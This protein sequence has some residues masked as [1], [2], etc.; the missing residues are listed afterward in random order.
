MNHRDTIDVAAAPGGW[1]APW[2][3]ADELADLTIQVA[4]SRVGKLGPEVV[5]AGVPEVVD[6]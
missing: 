4:S 2:P 3:S 1:P 6:P 5:T